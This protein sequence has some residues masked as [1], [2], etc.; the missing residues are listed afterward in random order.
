[1]E[2]CK[3]KALDVLSRTPEADIILAVDTV[4]VKD[5]KILEKPKDEE[6][7]V[8]MISSLVGVTHSVFSG[9]TLIISKPLSDNYQGNTIFPYVMT[10][11]EKTDVLFGNVS[12]DDILYYVSLGESLDKAGGYGI[13][14]LAASMVK[15]IRGDFYNVMGLPLYST[16]QKLNE[17]YKMF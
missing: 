14:S 17:A 4:V 1:M 10:W 8:R 6:N 15:E 5:D 3:M 13:Q 7:A 12:Q 16:C 11:H 2:T 9:C